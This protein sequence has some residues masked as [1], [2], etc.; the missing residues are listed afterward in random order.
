LPQFAGTI[1]SDELALMER[2]IDEG[3]ERIDGDDW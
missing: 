2:A 3:C 1:P